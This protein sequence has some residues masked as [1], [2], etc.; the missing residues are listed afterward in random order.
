MRWVITIWRNLFHKR[1]VDQ[2]LDEELRS[3]RQL[4]EDEKI[5][6]GADS[7]TAQREA[8][9]ELGGI[10]V[11]KEQVR[12]IRRGAFLEGFWTELRQAIRALRRNPGMTAM[13]VVML[14]LGIGASTIIFSVFEAALLRPLPFR[15]ADR[16]VELVETQLDLGLDEANLSEAD[17]WD[18]RDRTKS[19][20]SVGAYN[21]FQANLTGDG[22]PEKVSVAQVTLEFFRTLGVNPILGRDFSAGEGNA[23]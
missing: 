14:A 8:A 1:A 12:H 9:I 17:F 15:E 5:A 23:N 16:L 3:Y 6:A 13:C 4:L 2:I 11:I 19:F 21:G 18:L 10:E 7:Q 20:E 22:E